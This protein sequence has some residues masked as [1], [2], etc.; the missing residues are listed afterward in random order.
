MRGVGDAISQDN[1]Q[2]R[3]GFAGEKL[4]RVDCTDL[5]VPGPTGTVVLEEML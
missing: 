4:Y 5:P 3:S 2:A 1:Q